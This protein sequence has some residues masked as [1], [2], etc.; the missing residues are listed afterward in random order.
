M[1]KCVTFV[2]LIHPNLATFLLNKVSNPFYKIFSFI[3]KVSQTKNFFWKEGS[4]L[5]PIL[6]VQWTQVFLAFH[7]VASRLES[8]IFH[9]ISCFLS[10][11]SWCRACLVIV[12]HPKE[13]NVQMCHICH[14]NTPQPRH[15]SSQQCFKSISQ[16]IISFVP[17]KRF[18]VV[19]KW[20][21]CKRI[22]N[23]FNQGI[24]G[25]SSAWKCHINVTVRKLHSF[26]L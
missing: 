2:T 5:L 26:K 20:R 22:L 10:W 8:T 19:K 21:E 6:G 14:F 9:I 15:L 7:T 18:F 24:L 23:V 3:S 25:V 16:N 1:F 13:H 17:N 4:H 12:C 11:E